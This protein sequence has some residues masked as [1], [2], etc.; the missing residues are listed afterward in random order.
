M[1]VL[2]TKC[3]LKYVEKQTAYLGSRL[4]IWKL[5]LEYRATDRISDSLMGIGDPLTLEIGNK[6]LFTLDT[7]EGQVPPVNLKGD[8]VIVVPFCCVRN[9]KREGLQETIFNK[10]RTSV[11]ETIHS[12][13]T[14]NPIGRALL[15]L[16]TFEYNSKYV[17]K[18]FYSPSCARPLLEPL[19]TLRRF[20]I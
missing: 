16:N 1:K 4:P 7:W 2:D 8:G 3:N 19:S 9:P 20:S 11:A 15:K 10:G 6:N 5:F 18:K 13:F 14:P 12:T 17:Q